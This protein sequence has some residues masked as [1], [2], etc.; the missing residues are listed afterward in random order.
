[1][2]KVQRFFLDLKN[3][4]YKG[5]NAPSRINVNYDQAKSVGL[6][7]TSDELE[8]V[9]ALTNFIKHLQQDGKQVKALTFQN[10]KGKE[11]NHPSFSFN[12]HVITEKDVSLLGEIKSFLV[13]DFINTDFDYL[14]C[15]AAK[16]V[17]VFENILLKSKAKCR[18]GKYMEGH[19]NFELMIKLNDNEGTDVLI[20]QMYHYVKTIKND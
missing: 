2:N 1:M 20:Q 16:P 7:F 11:V 3:K 15:V 14:F 13:D 4:K 9:E 5:D 19:G 10:S 8:S 6:L 12:H 17:D 18:I